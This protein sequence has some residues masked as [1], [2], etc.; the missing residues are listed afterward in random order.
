MLQS[1]SSRLTIAQAEITL[2]VARRDA[3]GALGPAQ[4][5][6]EGGNRC[7]RLTTCDGLCGALCGAREPCCA[8]S[9]RG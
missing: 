6:V 8:A 4:G 7:R 1:K 3:Q 2:E 5:G 9:G